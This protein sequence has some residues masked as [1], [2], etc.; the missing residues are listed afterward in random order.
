MCS[1]RSTSE[2]IEHGHSHY[3]DDLT[4]AGHAR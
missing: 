1:A 4:T 2:L 3:L